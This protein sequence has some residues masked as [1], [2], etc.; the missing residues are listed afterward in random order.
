MFHLSNH[1]GPYFFTYDGLVDVALKRLKIYKKKHSFSQTQILV[2]WLLSEKT[3]IP[4]HSMIIKQPDEIIDQLCK[5]LQN[6][7]DNKT[8]H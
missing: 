5:S 6:V 7:T 2:D 3:E 8:N 1:T 4:V